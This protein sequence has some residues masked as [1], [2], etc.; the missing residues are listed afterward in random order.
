LI[1]VA[2]AAYASAAGAQT[3]SLSPEQAETRAFEQL[4]NADPADDAEARAWFEGAAAGGNPEAANAL[5]VMLLRGIGGPADEARARE[6][7]L[8]AAELG[9][10]GAN[11]TLS[12]LYIQGVWDFPRDPARGLSHAIAAAESTSN[13]RGAAYAQ[14]QVG[15]MILNG[16]GGPADPARA[17]EWVARAADNGA[18]RGMISRAVMLATGEGVTADP[19][20]AR[21]WYRRAAESHQLGN[22]HG[23]RGLGAMLVFGEGGPVELARGYAYLTLARD[24]GD[25]NAPALLRRVEGAIDADTRR[26]AASIAAAW[27][28]E[29]GDPQP[30]SVDGRLN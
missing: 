4:T 30:E 8:R 5:S 21:E 9:S 7:L 12:D 13:Q 15:M 11:M 17:Y 14:W 19:P 25:E 6:L 16:V 10:V 27:R 18:V 26:Q 22:S 24:G 20:A 3:G 1:V 2:F 28:L 29:H 23:L